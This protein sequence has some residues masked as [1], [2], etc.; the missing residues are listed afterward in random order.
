MM[1]GNWKLTGQFALATLCSLA[2]VAIAHI[3]LKPPPPPDYTNFA[4]QWIVIAILALFTLILL[5][6]TLCMSLAAAIGMLTG[7]TKQETAEP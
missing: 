1:K 5:I 7:R 4:P 3:V 2:A 6:A